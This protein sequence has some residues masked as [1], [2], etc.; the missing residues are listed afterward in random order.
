MQWLLQNLPCMNCQATVDQWQM[1]R[2]WFIGQFKGIQDL[3]SYGFRLPAVNSHERL[4]N[5]D[6]ITDAHQHFET[7]GVVNF[8]VSS[9]SSSAEGDY[10]ITQLLGVNVLN[11]A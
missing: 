5:C 4:T 3:L 2:G 9:L 8:V 10:G 7:G 1:S 11:E 6:L